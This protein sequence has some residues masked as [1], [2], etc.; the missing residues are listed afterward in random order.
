MERNALIF[1]KTKGA[2]VIKK[3]LLFVQIKGEKK[4]CDNSNLVKML[5][6]ELKFQWP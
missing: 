4:I 6:I 2:N 1:Y 3:P 5:V